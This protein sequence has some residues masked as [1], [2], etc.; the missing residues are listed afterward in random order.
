M[1]FLWIEW[2]MRNDFFVDDFFQN[3]CGRCWYG[4]DR[5]ACIYVCK[6]IR[7]QCWL[8]VFILTRLE[9][10]NDKENYILFLNT[11]LRVVRNA[12]ITSDIMMS[13]CS[14]VDCDVSKS[15]DDT[16]TLSNV[17]WLPTEPSSPSNFGNNC[18]NLF[19]DERFML[20]F[21]I[22]NSVKSEFEIASACA[23]VCCIWTNLNEPFGAKY[24]RR[25][26]TSGCT[27]FGTRWTFAWHRTKATGHTW[28]FAPTFRWRFGLN[29]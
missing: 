22:N 7:W 13:P 2:C 24:T 25:H 16:T 1:C 8:F 28:L 21:K 12:T 17:K 29:R 15:F 18:V 14:I 3:T 26:F 19:T 6:T 9:M 10:S 20:K 23:C 5:S 4:I 11:K 27:I